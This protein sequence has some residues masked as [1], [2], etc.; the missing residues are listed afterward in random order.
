[1][2]KKNRTFMLLALSAV[3]ALGLST[4]VKTALLLSLG[5]VV[6]LV[7]SRAITYPLVKKSSRGGG[8]II[9]LLVSLFVTSSAMMLLEAFLY[10]VYSG[11][12]V[13]FALTF[14]LGF[15][16]SST[17]ESTLT[18][19]ESIVDTLSYSLFFL[20]SVVLTA[21]LREVFGSGSFWGLEIGFMKNHLI[22]I[23]TKAQGGFITYGLSLALLSAVCNKKEEEK[24]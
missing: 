5:V 22:S 21:V 18:F 20:V 24:K 12:S 16:L 11:N 19:K 7:V 23:L 1:M 13:Y 4:N 17:S 10:D 9:S 6:S 15:A 3:P 2:E 8:A 14:L